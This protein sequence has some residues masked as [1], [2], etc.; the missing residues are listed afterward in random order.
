MKLNLQQKQL[1]HEL[2]D[3]ILKRSDANAYLGFVLKDSLINI[4]YKVE[5]GVTNFVK[6][7]LV[8]IDFLKKNLSMSEAEYPYNDDSLYWLH[9][10]EQQKKHYLQKDCLL[11]IL[12]NYSK[13]YPAKNTNSRYRNV[14]SMI[15]KMIKSKKIL[16]SKNPDPNKIGFVYD[17]SNLFRFDLKH[18]LRLY[19]N[20]VSFEQYTKQTD[21]EFT[22]VYTKHEALEILQK[23]D[24]K[25]YIFNSFQ[26]AMEILRCKN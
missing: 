22:G 17:K 1:L 4:V 13:K 10:T 24:S 14:Y 11:D 9:L 5:S 3:T 12:N 2:A 16:L 20:E 23:A 25:F 19:S 21:N 8:A 6:S 15:E 7:E 26:F 18:P